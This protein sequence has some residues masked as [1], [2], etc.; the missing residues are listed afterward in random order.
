[1][2]YNDR[3]HHL[4][5]YLRGG[6]L[7][8]YFQRH[9]M[10]VVGYYLPLNDVPTLVCLEVKF[11]DQS[12]IEILTYDGVSSYNHV[13]SLHGV[14]E[15]TIIDVDHLKNLLRFLFFKAEALLD[16]HQDNPCLIQIKACP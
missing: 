2:T 10:P 7:I 5:A 4:K 11:R 15:L 8:D 14:K 13:H 3:I 6:E 16:H 9:R 12:G 1:M